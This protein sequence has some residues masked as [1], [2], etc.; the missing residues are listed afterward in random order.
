MSWQKY[1][2]NSEKRKRSEKAS[3]AA[4]ARWDAYH[5]SIPPPV[6][7]LGLPDD[8]FRITVDNLITGQSHTLLFHPGTRRGRYRIDVDGKPWRECGWSAALELIR[9]SCKLMPLYLY[10]GVMCG[11]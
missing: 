1:R 11:N 8:C 5:A 3:R 7:P 10:D 9:K 2:S 4:Q 6:Y